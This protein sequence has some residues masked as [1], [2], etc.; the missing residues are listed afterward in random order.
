MEEETEEI[1]IIEESEEVPGVED[2][3]L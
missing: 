2:I 3:P 1:P